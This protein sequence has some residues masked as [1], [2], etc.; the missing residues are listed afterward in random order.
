MKISQAAINRAAERLAN[1]VYNGLHCWNGTAFV[2]AAALKMLIPSWKMLDA[3]RAVLIPAFKVQLKKYFK[4]QQ[5]AA[6]QEYRSGHKVKLDKKVWREKYLEI[7]AAAYIKVLNGAADHAYASIE[8]PRKSVNKLWTERNPFVNEYIGETLP[9][10]VDSI[11]QTTMDNIAAEIS[12]GVDAGEGIDQIADR[13][14]SVY[15]DAM[16]GG[17]SETIARTEVIRSYSAGTREAYAESGV[18]AGKMWV[19]TDDDRVRDSHW[20]AN[21]QIVALDE[22]FDLDGMETDG[23]GESGD[24]SEDINCRCAIAPVTD[25]QEV[26]DAQDQQEEE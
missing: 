20:A 17:R 26:A 18:V 16:D 13:I 23:P 21:G 22:P 2:V 9:D 12:D 10:I 7:M 1:K 5:A 3:K 11:N 4:M 24:P 14:E 19:A 8:T 6:M 25:P 15:E